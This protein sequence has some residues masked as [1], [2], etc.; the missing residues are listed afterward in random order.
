ML[1]QV[2]THLAEYQIAA[3]R[4][5]EIDRIG[6][7]AAIVLSIRTKAVNDGV[8]VSQAV[9]DRLVPEVDRDRRQPL[10]RDVGQ[11]GWIM[12]IPQIVHAHSQG[13]FQEGEVGS[14]SLLPHQDLRGYAEQR[15]SRPP[16][17]RD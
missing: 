14:L 15:R 8:T 5:G 6:C 16:V 17:A 13:H 11:P 1:P 12:A 9:G 7:P 2:V 4:W 3:R 10:A